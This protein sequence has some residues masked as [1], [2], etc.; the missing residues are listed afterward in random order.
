[1][2]WRILDFTQSKVSLGVKRGNLTVKSHA[3][4]EQQL[5]PLADIDV[6]MIGLGTALTSGTLHQLAKYD[7]VTLFTDWKFIPIGGVY[8]YLQE[9]AHNRIAAR[10]I[11]QASVSKNT[12]NSL[13]Q[14]V[15]RRLM[16][17][18]PFLMNWVALMNETD[19]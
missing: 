12:L 4:D 9:F 19:Y 17:K 7:C 2:G 15:V 1:M 14:Q 11:A 10:Q 5:V 18:P 16:V 8:P 6:V 3:T 13:W